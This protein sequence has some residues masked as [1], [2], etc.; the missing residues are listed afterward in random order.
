MS[1]KLVLS[2]YLAGLRERNELDALL[3]D[4]LQ[5]MGHSVLSRPQIGVNQ[6]GVDVVSTCQNDEGNAVVYL[7]VIKFGDVGR[8]GFFGS[9]TS[10]DSSI[11]QASN[12]FIR[13]R[14]L[15][16]HQSCKKKIVLVSNGFL[17]QEVQDDFAALSKEI[18][19]RELQELDFWGSDQLTPLIEKY[20]F[21]ES[22][23]LAQ[24]RTDLRAALAILEETDASVRKF[25]SFVDSC[26]GGPSGDVTGS[27]ATQKKYFLRRWAAAAMG[28]AVLLVWCDLEKNRKPGVIG[29][30][31]LLLRLW[32]DAVRVGL[33]QDNDVQG[34]LATLVNLQTDA[35]LRYHLKIAPHLAHRREVIGYRREHV[36]YADA[37]FE[38]LGRM[39][40]TLLFLQHT[41]DVE[42][43]RAYLRQQLVVFVNEHTVCRLPVLD[44]Q[45]IDLSL[46]LLALIGE[47]D[48]ESATA[49]LRSTVEY[50][51]LAVKY[52]QWL[53][54]DSDLIED[55][56]AVQ[57]G[58][59]EARDFFQIS[60]LFPMLG[61]FAALLGD[62]Q[63]LMKLNTAVA[64]KLGNVTLERWS[65]S[66]E[67]ETFPGSGQA[68]T[69]IGISK[70]IRHLQDMPEE[71]LAASL[72]A[73]PGAAAPEE[74]KWANTPFEVLAAVS[75]R[76]YR[77]PL[78]IWYAARHAALAL[79]AAPEETAVGKV[80]FPPV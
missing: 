64:P 65:P 21:D 28:W 25:I 74:F 49:L 68:L 36:F 58:D 7:F 72:K 79:A 35:L 57:E 13:Q 14:L 67:F 41:A 54:I 66:I 59:V 8:D 76:F 3:P 34:R 22:L 69:S 48:T 12:T 71:E 27:V 52:E 16:G 37:V 73:P 43:Q 4:L 61:T 45:S 31:Y 1:I 24:G 39:A 2:N 42:E 38:E 33:S 18:G 15:D 62:G 5:A 40:L 56:I 9:K 53:P 20:I 78:P 60:T 30:E 75:A 26:M 70:A 11:R 17:R 63:S 23:L 6:A 10:V 44:G 51:Q 55:A 32:A 29:G 80:E 50:F 19:E 47:R 46:A 77:H